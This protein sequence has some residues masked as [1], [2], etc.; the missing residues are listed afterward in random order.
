MRVF[1]T[2]SNCSSHVK[3][4]HIIVEKQ[5]HSPLTVNCNN[6]QL[7]PSNTLTCA[8]N[9]CPRQGA[10]V[11]T[12]WAH[13]T[14]RDLVACFQPSLSFKYIFRVFKKVITS[15]AVGSGLSFEIAS[16]TPVTGSIIICNMDDS[17][18]NICRCCIPF[19]S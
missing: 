15:A 6:I 2:I 16:A 11:L 5:K 7:N 12:R 1:L 14:Y 3:Y 13:C 4:K 9:L 18:S 10:G 17:A 19:F 8:S